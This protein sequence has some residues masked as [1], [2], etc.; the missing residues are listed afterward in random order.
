MPRAAKKPVLFRMGCPFC[1]QP[2]SFSVMQD[3][4]SVL[5]AHC[6]NGCGTCFA[7][8]GIVRLIKRSSY[9]HIQPVNWD[10]KQ[11][12]DFLHNHPDF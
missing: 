6:S 7:E 12:A 2:K 11:I 8:G 3:K 1:G 10:S 9:D 5:Y 4:Y